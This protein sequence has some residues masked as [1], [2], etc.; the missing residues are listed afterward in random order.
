MTF[1]YAA[2]REITYS[3]NHGGTCLHR[4]A[5]AQA[6]EVQRCYQRMFCGL[7]GFRCYNRCQSGYLYRG[8]PQG[9][10][11]GKTLFVPKTLVFFVHTCKELVGTHCPIHFI[12][13]RNKQ[14]D[15]CLWCH[16]ELCQIRF[17]VQA[18]HHFSRVQQQFLAH[19]SSQLLRCPH[20]MGKRQ[21]NRC[22]F[23]QLQSADQMFIT[24][25]CGET[26]VSR[27]RM[28]IEHMFAMKMPRRLILHLIVL[29][30]E[31]VQRVGRHVGIYVIRMTFSVTANEVANFQTIVLLN[32]TYSD[33]E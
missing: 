8:Q 17:V 19:Q 9:F 20:G 10:G 4:N 30:H 26:I 32:K 12:C 28:L 24:Y 11:F 15:C 18:L 2:H 25:F 3:I 16:A 6:I 1:Q 7:I 13:I 22:F 31:C 33:N 23:S 27:F 14:A 29:T 21:T 5:F